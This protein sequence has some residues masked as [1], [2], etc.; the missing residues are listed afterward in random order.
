MIQTSMLFPAPLY[1]MY[2]IFSFF[3]EFDKRRYENNFIISN[4]QSLVSAAISS[5]LGQPTTALFGISAP[6]SS[7]FLD[8]GIFYSRLPA[9]QTLLLSH[10]GLKTAE[11]RAVW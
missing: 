4:S 9:Q 5:S 10:S 7:C 11:W 3:Y 1:Y 6:V 8:V 2:K